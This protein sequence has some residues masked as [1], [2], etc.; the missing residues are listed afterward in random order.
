MSQSQVE[1]AP[2]LFAGAPERQH[3]LWKL[4][5]WIVWRW[6]I[7]Y[8]QFPKRREGEAFLLFPRFNL[9]LPV[10]KARMR[11]RGLSSLPF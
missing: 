5:A 8:S 6:R 11:K 10:L 7:S 4:S 1:I 3:N 9:S 2:V